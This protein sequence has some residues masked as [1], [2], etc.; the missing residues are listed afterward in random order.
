MWVWERFTEFKP[1]PNFIGSGEPRSARWNGVTNVKVNDVR[2]SLDSTGLSFLWFPY[3]IGSSNNIFST[4][5]KDIEQWVVVE[6]EEE[7][8]Y[9]RCLRAS[10]LVGS[11]MTAQYLPH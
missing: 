1:V 2:T 8:S 3:A 6:S 4:L 9:A 7:E 11:K 5:Y 10:E